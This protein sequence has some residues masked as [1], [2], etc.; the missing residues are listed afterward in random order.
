MA[1]YTQTVTLNMIPGGIHPIIHVSQFD[2]SSRRMDFTLHRGSQVFNI[3]SGSAVT[4]R[5]RRSDGTLFEHPCT[6]TDG[7]NVA[8]YALRTQLTSVA[9]YAPCEIR[10]TNSG[11]D[12]ISSETFIFDVKPTPN[13]TV[14]Q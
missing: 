8:T 2:Y 4:L 7:T 10:I 6:F 14:S 3:P 13:P 5:G 12:V 11:G 9:G 1:F